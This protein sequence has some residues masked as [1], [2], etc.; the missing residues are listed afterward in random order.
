[1]Y[2]C[3]KIT[4]YYRRVTIAKIINFNDLETSQSHRQHRLP[5]CAVQLQQTTPVVK[6]SRNL[7]L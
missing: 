6:L 3:R 2:I 5:Q 4:H 1:M 7:K